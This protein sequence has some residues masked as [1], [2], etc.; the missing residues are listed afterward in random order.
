MIFGRWKVGNR[1]RQ[2]KSKKKRGAI[3]ERGHA[4]SIHSPTV[5]PLSP[6]SPVR[7]QTENQCGYARQHQRKRW[8]ELTSCKGWWHRHTHTPTHLLP[9]LSPEKLTLPLYPKMKKKDPDVALFA[10]QIKKKMEGCPLLHQSKNPAGLNN[11]NSNNNSTKKKKKIDSEHF[12]GFFLHPR[13]W[14][15]RWCTSLWE[16]QTNLNCV[17]MPNQESVQRLLT[18]LFCTS[19]PC[20]F[21]ISFKVRQRKKKP[22]EEKPQASYTTCKGL[23]NKKG[24]QGKRSDDKAEEKD[25]CMWMCASNARKK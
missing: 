24:K 3:E 13:D 8:H 15:L 14:F 7:E 5:F 20:L 16:H 6:L 4:T 17:D 12:D 9:Y 22:Y 19:P 1:E 18:C 23:H 25:W 10:T 11:S 2:A 21:L